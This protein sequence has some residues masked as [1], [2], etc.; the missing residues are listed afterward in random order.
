M[1]LVSSDLINPSHPSLYWTQTTCLYLVYK[2]VCVNVLKLV[3]KH[4]CTCID[5]SK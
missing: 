3:S 1:W 2:S 5:I 4:T